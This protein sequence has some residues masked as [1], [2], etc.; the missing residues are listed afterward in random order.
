MID[1]T[2]WRHTARASLLET[3]L[4]D[5]RF[6]L[7]TL[8][9][10]PGFTFVAAVL[11]ALGI[12]AS[13]AVFSL[14][15]RVL[16]ES[17]PYPHAER[18]V[19]PWRLA[20]PNQRLGHDS[21]PWGRVPFELVARDAR[22]FSA[23]GAFV[24]GSYNLT[25]SGEPVRVDGLRASAG[26]F[27]ALGVPA[28]LGRTF[29]PED[30]VPGQSL[31]VVLGDSLWRQRFG[32]DRRVLGRTVDLDGIPYTVIGVMPPGFS[33]PHAN[34]M[35][36]CFTFAP[37]VQ[38][39]VPLALD[40]GPQKRNESD[41]L[42][43][44]ARLRPGVTV[45]QA[46]AELNQLVPR[47]E[48]EFPRGKG[49][50]FSR[51]T[52][53][54]LQLTAGQRPPLLLLLA[55]VGVV[56]LIACSN[57]GSLFLTRSVRRERELTV[58]AAVGAG[59]GRLI[60][61]LL[62]EGMVLAATAGLLG[63]LVAE[64][65]LWGVKAWAPPTIPRLSEVGL[66][67]RVLAFALAATALT[68]ILFSLAPAI[69]ATGKTLGTALKGGRRTTATVATQRLRHV[70]LVSQ[71]ALAFVLVVA[72]FLLIRTFDQLLRVDAGVETAHV[73]TFEL[74]LPPAKYRDA[75][76]IAGFFDEALRRIRELPGVQSAGVT[77][78]VP[79]SGATEQ[80][81]IRIPGRPARNADGSLMMV[82]YTVASSGYFSAAGTP[83][84]RGR[85]FLAAD[86]A[87]STPVTVIS[88]AMARAYWPGED[89]IGKQVAPA[90]TS[91][92]LATIVGI[93][94]DVKR[95]SLREV[96]M[97]EMYE[98]YTQKVWPSIL[99]MDVVVR[100]AI[101]PAAVVKE[102]RSTIHAVDPDMALA[103]IRTFDT[104][105][106]EQ[107]GEPRFATILL[108]AFGGLA[109]L[110]ATIGMYGAT[111]FSVAQRTREI[112]IRMALGAQRH[113]VGGMILAQGLRLTAAGTT[114]GLAASWAVTRV[115]KSLLYGVGATDTLTFGGVALLISA[116]ALLAC[117]VPSRRAMRV[118]PVVAL[119]E[120]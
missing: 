70:L 95:L 20:P 83:I 108:T 40:Q 30:D 5:V 105:A 37:S 27:P 16:L 84:L 33:F 112:G 71:V 24:G 73:L 22:S 31:R 118:D 119:H 64:A 116:T 57:V 3:L 15:D 55:A 7:R 92:P 23:F 110:L 45:A 6:A 102:A 47:L 54:S 19:F 104:I 75:A 53:M 91:F 68:G 46:Q 87:T 100:A 86:T 12:G 58:R 13:T 25:G 17:L 26:F 56:L 97:P 62:T 106:S 109:L 8:A 94:A 79:L 81:A 85:P 49:W 44:I 28:A 29:L 18:V 32:A 82:N 76:R 43:A 1:S 113:D 59:R 78:T 52:P 10:S 74:S 11:L 9:R 39:W 103:R 63:V 90:G 114:I 120:D 101:E 2:T 69:G 88:A 72:S 34:E 14:V 77:D 65:C 67:G 50:F 36:D 107:L 60:R 98:P 111:A 51:L 35:P 48:Q 115:M 42:A 61:Q 96:P 89:P 41:E 99:T 93:A 38:L 21:Y 80:T 117:H 66:D 4:G